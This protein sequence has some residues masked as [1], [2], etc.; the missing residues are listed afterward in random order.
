MVGFLGLLGCGR[1]GF[2]VEPLSSPVAGRPAPP[3][4]IDA[5]VN[6]DAGLRPPMRRDGGIAD[7]L[8]LPSD[9][10]Q[11][12]D[13]SEGGSAASEAGADAALPFC[14]GARLWDGCFYLSEVDASCRETCAAHGGLPADP[15]RHVGIPSQGGSAEDCRQI[16]LT[17][18]HT[19]PVDVGYRDDG[20]GFGCHHWDDGHNW[21]LDDPPFDVDAK[22]YP[23]QVVCNCAE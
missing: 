11:L 8:P 6:L 5:A 1:F 14:G 18:G 3:D 19:A 22:G 10:G 4:E 9:G 15:A 17:L 20:I 16:L 21:W 23:V 2:S 12:N 7:P 13:A